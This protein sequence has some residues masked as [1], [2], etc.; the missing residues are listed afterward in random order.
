VAAG[1]HT[2]SIL[3]EAGLDPAEIAALIEGGHARG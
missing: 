1:L 2:R 3:G